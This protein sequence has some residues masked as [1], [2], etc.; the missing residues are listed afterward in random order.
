MRSSV[1]FGNS[2]KLKTV[3]ILE[4]QEALVLDTENEFLPDRRAD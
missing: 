3:L 2:Y 1:F 4:L